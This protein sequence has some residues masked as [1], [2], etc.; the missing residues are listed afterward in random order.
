M[1]DFLKRAKPERLPPDLQ[2]NCKQSLMLARPFF[3]TG[4]PPRRVKVALP[5]NDGRFTEEVIVDVFISTE[6]RF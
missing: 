4:D 5:H 3:I 2:N 6:S 1:L